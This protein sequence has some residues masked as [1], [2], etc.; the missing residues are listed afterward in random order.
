M[1]NEGVNKW[2]LTC[3]E[4]SAREEKIIFRRYHHERSLERSAHSQLKRVERGGR[5]IIPSA[6]Q[7]RI[8]RSGLRRKKVSRRKLEM[9]A[10]LEL[11]EKDK[12]KARPSFYS[13]TALIFCKAATPG[14][15]KCPQLQSDRSGFK[16]IPRLWFRGLYISMR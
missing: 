8:A 1:L 3:K 5:S 16:Q 12:R 15:H 11:G 10:G 14:T 4:R 9:R 2:Y 6:V 7:S 13:G